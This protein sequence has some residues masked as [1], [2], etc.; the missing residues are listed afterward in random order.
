M[1]N[2][3]YLVNDL[4]LIYLFDSFTVILKDLDLI[5]TNK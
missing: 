4:F 1:F 2:F 3:A 5:F